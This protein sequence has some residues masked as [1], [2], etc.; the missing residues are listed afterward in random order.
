[1]NHSDMLVL[2]ERIKDGCRDYDIDFS[3]FSAWFDHPDAV[4]RILSGMVYPKEYAEEMIYF[5][6]KAQTS[7]IEKAISTLGKQHLLFS[8]CVAQAHHA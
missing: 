1:M 8:D 4:E 3:K 6:K 7:F 2:I 5:R